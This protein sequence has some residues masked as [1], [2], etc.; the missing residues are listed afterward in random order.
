V[1]HEKYVGEPYCNDLEF[2]TTI[3][4]SDPKEPLVS[5]LVRRKRRNRPIGNDVQRARLSDPVFAGRSRGPDFHS[6]IM[7]DINIECQGPTC[8]AAST[9]ASRTA[10]NGCRRGHEAP[11]PK[12]SGQRPGPLLPCSQRAQH[13]HALCDIYGPPTKPGSICRQNLGQ[14][15]FLAESERMRAVAGVALSPGRLSPAEDALRFV[16]AGP[17]LDCRCATPREREGAWTFLVAVR[18]LARIAGCC[19]ADLVCARRRLREGKG[20]RRR[21]HHQ[22]SGE[23]HDLNRPPREPGESPLREYGSCNGQGRGD[24]ESPTSASRRHHHANGQC[25][26]GVVVIEH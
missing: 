3:I 15:S 16:F 19:F 24:F 20:L 9:F 5:F 7:S 14:V 18:D 23:A 1:N 22:Q 2:D 6:I 25:R 12:S 17:D 11:K 26:P 8:P 21:Y 10:A 13:P 4:R